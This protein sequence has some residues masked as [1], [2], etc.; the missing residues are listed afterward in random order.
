L[1]EFHRRFDAR[2]AMSR[3]LVI[4]VQVAVAIV[5]AAGAGGPVAG[6]GAAVV[7][8]ALFAVGSRRRAAVTTGAAA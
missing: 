5:A 7:L 3:H 1:A 6:L 4:G 2:S 8:A